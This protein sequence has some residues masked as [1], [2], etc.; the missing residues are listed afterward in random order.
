[1]HLPNYDIFDE[2]RYFKPATESVIFELDG[3]KLG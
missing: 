3:L 2:E 1:M